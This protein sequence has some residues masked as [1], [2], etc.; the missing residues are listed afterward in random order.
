M[1][2]TRQYPPQ[3]SSRNSLGEEIKN[4]HPEPGPLM[5]SIVHVNMGHCPYYHITFRKAPRPHTRRVL[6]INTS[7]YKTGVVPVLLRLCWLDGN[8]IIYGRQS[9][10][11]LAIALTPAH[12]GIF[13]FFLFIYFSPYP[14]IS[15]TTSRKMATTIIY[16]LVLWNLRNLIR[17]REQPNRPPDEIAG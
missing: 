7:N 4:S 16:I 15:T 3:P 5:A 11:P 12:P 8:S 13:F 14:T 17:P 10:L 1:S 9:S 6:L 2:D